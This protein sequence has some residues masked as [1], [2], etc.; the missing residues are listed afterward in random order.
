MQDSQPIGRT[1]A[2]IA[3]TPRIFRLQGMQKQV[4]AIV[5]FVNPDHFIFPTQLHQPQLMKAML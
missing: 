3:H 4:I 2:R 1:S 5:A